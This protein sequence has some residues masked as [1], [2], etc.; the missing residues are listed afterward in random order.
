MTM[1]SGND[2]VYVRIGVYYRDLLGRLAEEA[3]AGAKPIFPNVDTHMHYTFPAEKGL[4]L[5][6]GDFLVVDLY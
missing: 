6:Q 3:V 5:P 4:Q 2:K 1:A